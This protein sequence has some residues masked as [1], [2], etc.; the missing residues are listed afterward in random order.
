MPSRSIASEGMTELRH[1]LLKR[2]ALLE[3]V[4]SLLEGQAGVFVGGY[5]ILL[6]NDCRCCEYQQRVKSDR[7]R[8]HFDVHRPRGGTIIY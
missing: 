5:N 3:I 2:H 8:T 7:Y 6:S 1:F 4:R